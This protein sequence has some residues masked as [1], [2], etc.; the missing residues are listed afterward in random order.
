MAS[1]TQ[2]PVVSDEERQS[3]SDIDQTAKST[4][5]DVANESPTTITLDD[6]ENPKKWPMMRKWKAVFAMS[7][8]VLMSPLSSTIVAPALSLISHD[9]AIDVPAEQ[10]MLVSIFMLGFAF[11]PLIASPMSEIYGRTRVVQSWNLIYLVFNTACGAASSKTMLLILRFLSGL[12]GSAT[13]GIGGGTLS[14]LFTADERGKA[15]AIY[16]VAPL[17]GPVI[18]PIMGGLIAQHVSWRWSFWAASILDAVVQFLG[19]FLLEETHTPVLLRWK[20]ARLN[21]SPPVTTRE[22]LT[23]IRH[24]LSSRLGRAARLL[25]TQPIIQVLTVYN[26]FLF[27]NVAILYATFP[28]LWQQVYHQNVAISGLHYITLA[29]GTAFA[30]EVCTLINDRIFASLKKK[31]QGKTL[32]EFRVPMMA[33]ATVLLSVGLFWYGWSAEHKL[34]WIMPDIGAACFMA[35]GVLCSICINAYIIDTYGDSAASAIAA[36]ATLR[37]LA[38]FS[39]PLFAPYVFNALGYGWTGTVLGL[40]GLGIGLPG[41]ALL[42]TFGGA[43]RRQSPFA[44]KVEGDD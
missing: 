20:Q 25:L 31:H 21:K 36:V 6:H 28:T 32:P 18:G 2:S 38:G 5:S 1:T 12:F 33:P 14:D 22:A 7:S 41:V 3:I 27:G 42:W 24:R 9:L 37:S 35:G 44:A 15:V 34:P 43:L 39:F 26:A 30:S 8:F 17:L 19:L 16:S 10:T 29:L 13:L 11:G 40:C 4:T 23:R